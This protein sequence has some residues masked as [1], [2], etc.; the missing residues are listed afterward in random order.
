MCLSLIQIIL[1]LLMLYSS[2]LKISL[3]IGIT[4]F[5]INEVL[6]GARS[7]DTHFH[8]I[9]TNVKYKKKNSS[10]II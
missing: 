5:L 2:S 10:E 7:N 4:Y 9:V 3:T 8:P 1:R 6:N